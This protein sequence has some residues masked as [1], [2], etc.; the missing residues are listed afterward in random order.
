MPKLTMVIGANEPEKGH[1]PTTG[2]TESSYA[3]GG[4]HPARAGMHPDRAVRTGPCFPLPR[5]SGDGPALYLSLDF[6]VTASPHTRGWTGSGRPVAER[7]H[8]FPAHAGM[9]PSNTTGHNPSPG[10]PRTRGDGPWPSRALSAGDVASP[11]TR[12]C[13]ARQGR[14][15]MTE[16]SPA[17][18]GIRPSSRARQGQR[19]HQPRTDWDTPWYGPGTS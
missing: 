16:P 13:T 5:R 14:R 8:G 10:L 6:S 12:G 2:N 7:V 18:A 15:R 11:H 17:Q 19:E 1:G 4:V 3:G 9:D